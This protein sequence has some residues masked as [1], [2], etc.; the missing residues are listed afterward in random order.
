MKPEPKELE[1]FARFLCSQRGYDPD[2]LEPGDMAFHSGFDPKLF[3]DG[4]YDAVFNDES[5]KGNPHFTPDAVLRNGDPAML[6]WRHF[7]ED[8]MRILIFLEN[9][10]VEMPAGALFYGHTPRHLQPPPSEQ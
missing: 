9:T 8:A 6:M 4:G 10:P 5:A 7:V 2:H 3:R 1:A